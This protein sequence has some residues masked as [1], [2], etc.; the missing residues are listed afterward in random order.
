MFTYSAVTVYYCIRTTSGKNGDNIDRMMPPTSS[1]IT[2]VTSSRRRC[3]VDMSA[4]A[5]VRVC[6]VRK[7]IKWFD[8][9]IILA[10]ESCDI[11]AS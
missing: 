11:Y 7:N 3:D 2:M 10:L 4:P 9:V 6:K 5:R 8:Y 1:M